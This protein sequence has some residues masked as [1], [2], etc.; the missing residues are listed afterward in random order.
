MLIEASHW[1]A[2]TG[3]RGETGGVGEKA[4]LVLYFGDRDILR[5]GEVFEALRSTYPGA[6]VV[7]GSTGATILGREL[8]HHDAVAVA[9]RFTR[10]GVRVAT[11]QVATKSS[12]HAGGEALA[13]SLVA[14]DLA[15]V[16][17]LADGMS[18][19][20]SLL[21]AGLKN[22]LGDA[23]PIS[24]GMTG[25]A[26]E[27]TQALVGADAGPKSNVA[28]AIGFYGS[29]VRISYGRG[30]GWD[31]FGPRRR[32]TRSDGNVLYEL[33]GKPAFELYER[34]LGDEVVD[35]VPAGVLFPLLLSHPDRPERSF[36]RAALGLDQSAAAMTLAGNVPE[37]WMARLMRG[38]LDRLSLAAAAAAREARDGLPAAV[39]GD[40]L[41]IIVSCTG[42][43]LLMGQRTIEEVDAAAQ[44]IPAD[45][46]CV[47]F[48]SYGE[49]APTAAPEHAELHNQTMTIT[50]LAEVAA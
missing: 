10:T 40:R 39:D 27:Y 9:L 7:G 31:A 47:G 43:M 36:V 11:A 41:A 19:N 38:S 42:R 2:H 33:D 17:V 45:V 35:G 49:I 30:C 28:A 16:F 21:T 22:V 1:S 25:D 3:W 23:C 29:S 18:V 37:G 4:D 32:I 5:D 12:S 15:A 6:H 24:G 20:G 26:G 8:G 14:P 13:R 34:Y 44:E 48:Y 50:G 46:H